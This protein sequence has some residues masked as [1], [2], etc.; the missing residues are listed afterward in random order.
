M[1]FAVAAAVGPQLVLARLAAAA[2]LQW[3]QVVQL[4]LE[5]EVAPLLQ[6]LPLCQ[7]L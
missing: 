2:L 5:D 1:L 3:H 4:D 6:P 7:I